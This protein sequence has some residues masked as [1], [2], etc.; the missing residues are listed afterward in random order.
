M[1]A[2]NLT[3][4]TKQYLKYGDLTPLTL[5]QVF[6]RIPKYWKQVLQASNRKKLHSRMFEVKQ[7]K[8]F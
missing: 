5:H 7:L 3:Y 1:D 6:K 4:A 2:E 8:L